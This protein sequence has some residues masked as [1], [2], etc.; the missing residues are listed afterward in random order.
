[1]TTTLYVTDHAI[2]RY[3]ERVKPALLRD[4]AKAELEALLVGAGPAGE[5]PGWVGYADPGDGYIE[6]ADGIVAAVSDGCVTTVLTRGSVSPAHRAHRRAA[7]RARRQARLA[8]AA[9]HWGAA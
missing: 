5:A 2:T 4:Q 7:R 3:W 1:M 6:V 9:D 8:K